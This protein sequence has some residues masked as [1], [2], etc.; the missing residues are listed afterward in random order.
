M[1]QNVNDNDN[2]TLY[3]ETLV[4]FSLQQLQA[5]MLIVSLSENVLIHPVLITLC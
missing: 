2:C 1:E 5:V 3:H 4:N